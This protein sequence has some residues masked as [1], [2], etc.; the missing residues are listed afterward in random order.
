[1]L[2]NS[3]SVSVRFMWNLPNNAHR[4]FVEPLGGR[5]AR[6]MLFGRYISFINSAKKSPKLIVQ[7]I[8]QIVKDDVETI[9]GKNIR[10]ILT[11]LDQ[12]DIFLVKKGTVKN[13]YKFAKTQ[14][15]DEWKIPLVKEL[16]DINQGVLFI[17]GDEN[18]QFSAEELTE[19]LEHVT[20]I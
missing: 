3:C 9:T 8:L 2:E 1:M 12:Q 15:E 11:E 14:P 7:Q 5:H 18:G 6:S 20:T 16:T 4:Y 10:Y 19:I 17:P 13:E